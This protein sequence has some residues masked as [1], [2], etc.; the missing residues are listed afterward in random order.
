MTPFRSILVATDFSVDGNNAVRR[1]ALLAQ[2]HDARLSMLHVVNPAG[3]KPLR[4]WFSR[5]ID[6]DLKTAQARATLRRF[7]A[8]IVGRHDVVANFEVL[9]GDAFE[10]L[11]RASERVD[12]VVLGQRG[13]SPLKDLVIG[14][15]A[16]RLLRTCR[17]PVLVVKQAVEAPYRRVL[18]PVDFTPCS[19]AA[20]RAAAV[21]APG[22]GIHVFHAISSTREAV[23]READVP[24][25]VIRESRAREEAGV[26]ARM[27]RSVARLGLD[28]RRMSFV[29]G[30]GPAARSTLLQ[31]QTLS[32]D[33][34][35]AG[36][37]GRSTVAGFLLGSVSSRLL[38]GSSCDMVIIPR[39]VCEPVPSRASAFVRPAGHGAAIDTA[40]LARDAAALA[41]AL[42]SAQVPAAAT[43]ARESSQRR[44]V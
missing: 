17:T 7:A 27:R 36:K 38:A 44:H 16:D 19:D 41:G 6:I 5:S 30:R 23:L 43:R 37:Q 28:S 33:L 26:S 34:I 20:V 10:E 8:E 21:L 35:V 3:F 12:L 40:S 22:V 13:K 1:A 4:D 31:A 25:A 14:K 2:Q 29:L 18:V 32:A 39:P 9:V 24:E 15:T 11:L 42:T